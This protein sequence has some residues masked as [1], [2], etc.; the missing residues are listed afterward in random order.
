MKEFTYTITDELGIHARPAGLLVKETGKFK[1]NIA[2][3]CN[4]KTADAKKIFSIMS[5]AAKHGDKISVKIEGDDE[6]EAC[7]KLEVFFKSNF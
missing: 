4:G 7:E 3:E 5:L 6:I 2:L 1:S